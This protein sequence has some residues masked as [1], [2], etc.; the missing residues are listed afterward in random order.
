MEAA[1]GL[2]LLGNVPPWR[3]DFAWTCIDCSNGIIIF[4]DKKRSEETPSTYPL[5]EV[6]SLA[7]KI[8]NSTMKHKMILLPPLTPPTAAMD[9]EK[10][11]FYC[12]FGDYDCGAVLRMYAA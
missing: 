9:I 4:I 8:F 5:E 12:Y 2:R 1:F 3:Y 7:G 6:K 11:K 10:Y